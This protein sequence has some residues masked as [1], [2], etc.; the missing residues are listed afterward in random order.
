MILLK[1]V[2]KVQEQVIINSE[3]QLVLNFTQTSW[4]DIRDQDNGRLAYKSYAPG[5]VLKV[6]N[7]GPMS[8][9]IGN[10]EGVTVKFN[11]DDFGIEQYREGVYAKFIVNEN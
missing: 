3:D 1:R 5:E 7:D 6:S 9:F 4:I 2:S 8:V 11:G 10:A